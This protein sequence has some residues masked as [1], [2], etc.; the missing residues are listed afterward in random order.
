[1]SLEK[2]TPKKPD[3]LAAH[4]GKP[5]APTKISGSNIVMISLVRTLS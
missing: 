5:E 2:N 1:M 4:Q 3:R